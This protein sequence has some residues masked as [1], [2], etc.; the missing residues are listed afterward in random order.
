MYTYIIYNYYTDEHDR[1]EGES[2][3]YALRDAGYWDEYCAGAIRV[4]YT[5]PSEDWFEEEEEEG[6]DWIDE[7]EE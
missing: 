5:C 2:L 3:E 1:I 4:V 6:E 7:D